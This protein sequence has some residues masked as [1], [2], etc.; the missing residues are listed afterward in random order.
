MSDTPVKAAIWARV[1][2]EEQ[3]PENQ[4]RQLEAWAK[5][6]GF[7]VVQVYRSQASGWKGAHLKELA[8]VYDGAHKGR[9]TVLLVWALDRLSREGPLPTL[10]IVHRLGRLGV[11]VRS[12]QEPWTEVAG[13]FRDVLLA[14]TGWV[15]KMESQRRSERTRAGLA[16]AAADGK[17]LGRPAGAKDIKKRRRT[18]Y[19]LRHAS[20][21]L[22]EK[23]GS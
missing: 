10:E 17:K 18:G 13:E 5:L 15:A 8:E 7:E 19:L 6:L 9:F 20:Q 22:R 14:I 21:D 2:T 23:Y 3:D 1:S 11:H 16:R 4:V 12:M